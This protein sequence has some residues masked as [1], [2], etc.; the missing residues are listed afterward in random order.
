[1]DRAAFDPSAAFIA[2]AGKRN[3]A[4]GAQRL[5]EFRT[6]VGIVVRLL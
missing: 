1:M 4:S 2:A 5:V 3:L 6:F